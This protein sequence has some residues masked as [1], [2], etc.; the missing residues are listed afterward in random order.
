MRCLRCV[1]SLPLHKKPPCRGK[2]HL[3][4]IVDRIGHNEPN[5]PQQSALAVDCSKTI[6]TV[7]DIKHWNRWLEKVETSL[8]VKPD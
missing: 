4:F 6:L 8:F 2:D 1:T 5:C 3:K 7:G